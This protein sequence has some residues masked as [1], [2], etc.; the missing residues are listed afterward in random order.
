MMTKAKHFSYLWRYLGPQ[1][2]SYRLRHAVRL[3]SGLLRRELPA[4]EWTAQPLS[5]Y[6][7]DATL[8]PPER[9]LKYRRL[10]A[11]AFFFA[12]ADRYSYMPLLQSWDTNSHSPVRES[13]EIVNGVLTYFSH[14]TAQVGFPPDWH[15]NP[16]SG[17]R[18]PADQH[19]SQIKD[20]QYGDMKVIW[21]LSR[22]SF[23]YP[24]AR[25]HWRT[26]DVRYAEAFWQ[27][28]EDWRSHNPPQHGPN[29]KCGQETT[30]RIMAWCFGLY[31]FMDASCTTAERVTNL[32]QMIAVSGRR[33]AAHF[34]Y[35]LSQRNN[36]GISEATGLWTIGLLFPELREANSWRQT[37]CKALEAQARE[38]IYDDGAFAQHSVN[39]HRLMLHDYLWALRL[40]DLHG[41]PF[42]PQLKERVGK[43]AAFLFQTQDDESGRV[44]Y[45]G[46]NDGAL[47]LPLSNCDYQDFRP[48][49]Q[50]LHLYCK[51]TRCYPAGPWDEDLLWLFGP[52]ACHAPVVP[53]E[54]SEMSASSGGYY[55]LRSGSGFAFV[56]CASFR[57]RPG[58]ADMLHTDIWWR[59]Q[60]VAMDAGT[61]SYNAQPPWDNA[62]AG[63]RYHNTVSID[64]R[65]QM[66]AAGKFLWLPWLKS[67]VLCMEKSA[68]GLLAY[69]EG[70]HDGY[71]RLESPVLH[72]RGILRLG[73]GSWLVLDALTG[74]ETS[75]AEHTYRL[76][77]LLPDSPYDWVVEG[78][79]G[80]ITL[81]TPE[82]PYHVDMG[83]AEGK[84]TPS[85]VRAEPEGVRGWHA[86]YYYYREPALSVD[87]TV[88]GQRALFWTLFSPHASK[89]SIEGPM[90]GEAAVHYTL[91][92]IDATTWKANVSLQKPDRSDAALIKSARI[93]ASQEDRLE[94]VG[95]AVC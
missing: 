47:I 11:P 54:R 83:L 23:V 42:S 69:W 8:A 52:E 73:D 79:Q 20:F 53:Q 87:L 56:R 19:W 13:D 58:Q 82:G 93:S 24:L 81:S 28:V 41:K 76:H 95:C 70:Q 33:I 51:G 30:F 14:T 2:L 17:Q 62:L 71:Q 44:P 50:A 65:D 18:A 12:S 64:D 36:H 61:Y 38:L 27:S 75:K 49:V 35:A 72:R 45:Y 1:W 10:H 89:V 57:H 55:T 68:S 22:F 37:G 32:A 6:L 31:A 7:S 60:N 94:V 86:P 4:T 46:Q 90:P 9:Y 80:R 92:R 34:D 48:V 88:R 77:W 59:G 21:E 5:D 43:A 67:K 25:A 39:Y 84:G 16:F 85:L 74:P 78:E 40:G 26:G 91:L 63:T 66:D 3:R 29:W 15:T